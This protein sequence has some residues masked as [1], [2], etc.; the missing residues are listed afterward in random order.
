MFPVFSA[1][2]SWRWTARR[3]G[4]HPCDGAGRR[5][6]DHDRIP[7]RQRWVSIEW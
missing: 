1:A 6:R 5:E 4:L 3:S 2:V 7:Q